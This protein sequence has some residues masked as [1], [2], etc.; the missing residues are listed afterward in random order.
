M[1]CRR[2]AVAL[3]QKQFKKGE[4]LT[5]ILPNMPEYLV[6]LL[7]TIEAGLVPTTLNPT[8]TAGMCIYLGKVLQIKNQNVKSSTSLRK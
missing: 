7:G 2:F 3:K 8:F 6:I 4:I 1:L 5:I